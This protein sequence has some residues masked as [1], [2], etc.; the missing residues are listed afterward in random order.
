M[1]RRNIPMTHLQLAYDLVMLYKG[2]DIIN[3]ISHAQHEKRNTANVSRVYL[4]FNRN[5]HN[6]RAML[7]IKQQLVH[8]LRDV[9]LPQQQKACGA[10]WRH[11]NFYYTLCTVCT[12]SSHQHTRTAAPRI[13]RP[14]SPHVVVDL[15]VVEGQEE[16]QNG[17][18]HDDVARKYQAAGAPL[19]HCVGCCG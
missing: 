12:M 4:L 13:R 6:F 1:S 2:T 18:E 15:V 16:A 17:N 3:Y 5:K 7:C 19:Y 10:G 14:S 11:G 9:H 8:V